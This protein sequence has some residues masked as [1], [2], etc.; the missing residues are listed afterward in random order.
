MVRQQQ[1]GVARR[2]LLKSSLAVAGAAAVAGAHRRAKADAGV[3]GANERIRLG[4]IG[5][6]GLGLGHHIPT[7]MR[8][9][10][11]PQ[12]NIELAAVCDIYE[13]RKQR[14]RELSGAE[15]F[16]DYRK[17]LDRKD[18][19]GVVIVTPDHWHA[20]MA[21][22]AMEAG[23][24]IHVE[25]PM[26]LYWEEAKKLYETAE[27]TRRV[28]QVGAEG[29]SLDVFWQA[30]RAIRE[31]KIGKVVWATGGVYRNVPEGDWNWPMDPDCSPK[32]LDWD[33]FLGPAPKRP[34]DPERYFRYRKYWDYSGGP[35]HDLLAHVLSALQVS[36]GPEF[37]R[38]VSAAGGLYCHK[39]RETP[40][41]F[42]MMVEY[43]SGYTATL[44]CTQCTESGVETVIRGER[45]S[46]SFPREGGRSPKAVRIDPEP[47]FHKDAAP[48]TIPGGPRMDHDANF[49]HCM[50]TREKTHC[51][52]LTGYKVMVAL[53]LAVRSWREGRMFT[54]D[55]A[56][57]EIVAGLT[58]S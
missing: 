21:I 18:I 52:A 13:P 16:H 24:D 54:F 31:G 15:V 35:A 58:G 8:M 11:D 4:V 23:K 44:F 40:D 20:R 27:R 1:A 53:G 26:T 43:P 38:R 17:L 51:D 5:C 57:Q 36:V 32:N 2:D 33:A 37:P 39:D 10:K 3:L 41:V 45:G 46:I 28:V 34:F 6:G 55:P 50:L 29:T 14:A 49:I 30:N 9:S 56:R 48:V 12:F 7:L 19:H 25:K 42:H 47:A 22:D